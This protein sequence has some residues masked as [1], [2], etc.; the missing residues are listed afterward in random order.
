MTKYCTKFQ[1]NA[2]DGHTLQNCKTEDDV[3]ELG[4]DIVAKARTLL[5]EIDEIQKVS[6]CYSMTSFSQH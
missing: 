2:V 3:K 6:Y 1:E 5:K 4:I